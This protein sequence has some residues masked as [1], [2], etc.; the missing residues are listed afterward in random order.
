MY[1]IYKVVLLDKIAEL[2]QVCHMAQVA[3]DKVYEVYGAGA[4]VTNIINQM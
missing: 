2:I 4:T 3:M 1:H